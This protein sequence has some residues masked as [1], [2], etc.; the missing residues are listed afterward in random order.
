MMTSDINDC[1]SSCV[2]VLPSLDPN[3]KFDRVID[4]LIGAGFRHILIVDDGS[5]PENQSHFDYAASFPAC[6]LLRHEVN[7]GK[8]RALKDAFAETLRV[9]PDAA[10]VITIDGDG[11]HLTQD[12]IAC[13][14]R[15]LE[16]KNNVVLGCRNFDLPG[17]P[18]RSVA[19]N[20][21]TSRM[22]RL[23]YGIRLSD[24]QTG[25]RAIPQAYL[26]R[27]CDIEGERFEYETN[28]LLM[29]KRWGIQFSEQPIETVYEDEN[30]GSH[31]DTFRDSWRIFK[32]M[33]KFMLSSG[34]AFLIDYI[35]YYLIHRFF[36]GPLGGM[37]TVCATFV[38]KLVSSFV[39]FSA[40]N[41][42]VF[43]N[44]GNYRRA[45]GRYYVLWAAQTIV[46]AALNSGLVAL[47]RLLFGSCPPF[48]A[49][50]VKIPVDV[51][52]F[53]ISYSIQRDW[54]FS[55]KENTVGS[56]TEKNKS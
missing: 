5:S 19:G 11:Q 9:F 48:A 31:Y 49:T 39:N 36:S 20:K 44:K 26:E 6:T 37:T 45:L 14:N 43:R 34:S 41:S 22:F 30:A 33:F 28:M 27:F 32:I 35:L 42:L 25:L 55:Q 50:L 2:I 29:M 53:G 18:A 17:V 12:I 23:C 1:R 40:N 21:T 3:E 7:K 38:G 46:S 54:V 47:I 51:L 56:P 15:M 4:G 8:G 52:L 13:G 16:E 24:T 10:G